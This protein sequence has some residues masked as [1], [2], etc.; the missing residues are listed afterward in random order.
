M[1]IKEFSKD[2]FNFDDLLE[3]ISKYPNK[4]LYHLNLAG[5]FFIKENELYASTKQYTFDENLLK[6]NYFTKESNLDFIKSDINSLVSDILYRINFK[7]SLT[8]NQVI[9][10]YLKSN[11]K[12]VFNKSIEYRI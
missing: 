5:L 7:I 9:K 1:I 6:F 10:D 4:Y 12:Y 3:T 11:Y 2:S 8:D